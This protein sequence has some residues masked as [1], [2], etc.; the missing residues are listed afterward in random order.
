MNLPF[1][2]VVSVVISVFNKAA[3]LQKS[4]GSA[5]SQTVNAI[6]VVAIDAESTDNSLSELHRLATNDKRLR[7]I[8]Q[9]NQG[10]SVAKNF[11]V[12][13]SNADLIAFL[14]A[15]DEWDHSYLEEILTLRGNF[16]LANAFV[17]GF[18]IRGTGTTK[19]I[20]YSTKQDNGYILD[21]FD[22]RLSG[23][24]V[25]SSSVVVE[26]SAFFATKG[27]PSIVASAAANC[28]W[29][30]DGSGGV[31][32]DFPRIRPLGRLIQL[33]PKI[34][35]IPEAIRHLHDLTIELPGPPAEDQY[36]HDSIAIHGR[37]AFSA[38]VLSTYH[39]D[40]PGQTIT[41][42][43][44]NKISP[45]FPH[46]IRINKAA[47]DEREIGVIP[48]RSLVSYAKYLTVGETKRMVARDSGGAPSLYTIYRMNQIWSA[49]SRVT[50]YLKIIEWRLRRKMRHI[51]G[52]VKKVY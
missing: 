9:R 35:D 47:F 30:I 23:W 27:F 24:G 5:L 7:V 10:Y 44:E 26:K 13:V 17:T 31:L 28:A 37:Y 52:L 48:K 1:K 18:R 21:Y 16:P 32:Q 46:I 8:S 11:G 29:L 15:D 49:S 12:K 22:A 6:E 33:D 51:L 4:I 45:L 25:H 39:K 36:V 3:Y 42:V 40:I 2:P 14:D 34:V 43:L 38:K 19:F 41:R 50:C 20:T